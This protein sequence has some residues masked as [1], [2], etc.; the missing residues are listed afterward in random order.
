MIMKWLKSIGFKKFALDNGMIST[1]HFLATSLCGTLS[2]NQ[3]L[4]DCTPRQDKFM[5]LFLEVLW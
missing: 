5:S 1:I 2:L 4:D 3:L